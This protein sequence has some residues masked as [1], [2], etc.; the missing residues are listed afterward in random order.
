MK[1]KDGT[2][3]QI[4]YELYEFL[5]RD[6][7]FLDYLEAVGVENWDGWVEAKAMQEGNDL[8]EKEQ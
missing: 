4:T 2:Y 5:K 6:S 3:I 8:R 1:I 7:E